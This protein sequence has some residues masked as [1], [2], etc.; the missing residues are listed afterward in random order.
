MLI[1]FISIAILHLHREEIMH[2]S[3]LF[4]IARATV[5]QLITILL[6]PLTF[7]KYVY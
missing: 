3:S 4:E 5:G 7:V 2:L 1:N 6:I